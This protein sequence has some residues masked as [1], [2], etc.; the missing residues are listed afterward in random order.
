LDVGIFAEVPT[1]VPTNPLD[2]NKPHETQLD[3]QATKKPGNPG[4]P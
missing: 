3:D 4:L 1:K 2:A